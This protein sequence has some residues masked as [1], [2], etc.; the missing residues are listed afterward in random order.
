[1]L[2]CFIGSYTEYPVPGFGGIGHGI[3]T[4]Q[5]NEKSGELTTLHTEK[6]RNP[7]Y[8][9]I[10]DDHQF[11][12]C[13]TELDEGENPKVKAY[14][15]EVDFSLEFLNEQPISGGFPCHIASLNNSVFVAC[16][17]SGNIIQLPID[18]SGRLIE[19]KTD[20]H[21]KGSSVNKTRQE[22]PHPHQVVVH[23]NKKDIYV[24]DLGIDA[25]K[26]YRVEGAE[27]V[28]NEKNDCVVSQGSGPRHLAFNADGSLGYVINELTGTISVLKT[29]GGRFKVLKTY[30]AIPSDYKEEPS[31]SAIRIHPN[32]TFLYAAVRKADA[33]AIFGIAEDRL[34]LIEHQYTQGE[35]LREFNITPD[36]E[37][38]IA[39]H[40]NSH[41]V[42]VY[43]IRNDGRLDD[44]Y[45]TKSILSP[46]CISFGINK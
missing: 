14:K 42:V 15:I 21:H 22:A 38:M 28:P 1:M 26:A 18:A 8:L 2:T 11:L 20:Y 4:V 29:E 13:P 39:C 7:S 10:S 32:G 35:E 16:Y 3:Y 40:Q 33:L 12:Y 45:R 43:R 17:A 46:V 30:S 25:I 31:G 41:D 36:G 5:L 23:P 27:L 34:V 6:V 37:W 19:T 44:V 9:A 24:C